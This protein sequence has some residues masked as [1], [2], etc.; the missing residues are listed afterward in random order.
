MT[1][2]L[3]SFC[4][5]TVPISLRERELMIAPSQCSWRNH[6]LQR[7]DQGLQSNPLKRLALSPSAW[8]SSFA[9]LP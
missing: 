8:Q 7:S 6:A 3:S 9:R 1:A 2:T 4:L 5:L